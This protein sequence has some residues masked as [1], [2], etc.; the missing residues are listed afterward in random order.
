MRMEHAIRLVLNH[1]A[2]EEL[3]RDVARAVDM[4][5]KSLARREATREASNA[6]AARCKAGSAFVM[7]GH[8]K[9]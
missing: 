7:G 1:I 9:P 6:L 4:L 3:P 5:R 2:D 8:G